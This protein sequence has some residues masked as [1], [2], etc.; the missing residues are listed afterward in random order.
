MIELLKEAD[1]KL[2]FLINGHHTVF[3]DQAM[4]LMTQMWFWFP[5]LAII[6]FFLFKKYQR[7]TWM[8]LLCLATSI[9]LTDKTSVFIKNIVKRSR[10]THNVSIEDRV[11]V[12]TYADGHEYRGGNYGFPSS[13]ASNSFGL[14]VLLIYFFKSVT[15]HSWWIFPLW[16]LLFCYTRVYLGVHYPSDIFC[17]MLLGLFYGFL[18]LWIYKY[19]DRKFKKSSV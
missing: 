6:I 1:L 9:L 4:Y 8:V 11:D 5:I 18:L 17:G 13:H 19:I 12:Y 16:A 2:L 15:R 10:P 3:W 14:V 7:R